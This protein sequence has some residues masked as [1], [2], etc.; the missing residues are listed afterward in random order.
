MG[1]RTREGFGLLL[2][3]WRT[4]NPL[5]MT[6]AAIEGYFRCGFPGLRR[7]DRGEG[8]EWTK[9]EVVE[10]AREVIQRRDWRAAELGADPSSCFVVEAGRPED[11]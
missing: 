5:I 9:I 2:F 11:C 6:G 8:R 7:K 1:H 10:A 4:G 3:F